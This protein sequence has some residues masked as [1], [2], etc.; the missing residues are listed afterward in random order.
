MLQLLDGYGVLPFL[1]LGQLD[2]CV[3]CVI[4]QALRFLVEGGPLEAGVVGV[5]EGIGIVAC[6]GVFGL[7]HYCE[8]LINFKI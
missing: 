6:Y 5:D 1:Q 3:S 7:F 2:L 4:W 8:K